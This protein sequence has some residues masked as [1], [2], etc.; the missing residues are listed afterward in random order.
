MATYV[1]PYFYPV[2]MADEEAAEIEIE[3]SDDE[4]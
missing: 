2:N 4:A 1:F 3:L